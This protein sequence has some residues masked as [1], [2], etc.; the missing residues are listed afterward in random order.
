M[1]LTP[2]TLFSILRVLAVSLALFFVPGGIIQSLIEWKDGLSILARIPLAFALS[3]GGTAVLGVGCYLLKANLATAQVVWLVW[4]VALIGVWLLRAWRQRALALPSRGF[5]KLTWAD[6][7]AF[8]FALFCAGLAL[9]QGG[10]FSHRA[11]GFY[12]LAAIRRQIDQGLVLPQGLLYAYERQPTGLNST[13]GT[14][15]LSLALLT[16]WSGVDIT[17]L[18]QH[19]PI[20]LT[21]LLI[22]SFYALG[23]T[24]LKKP[25]LAF[26]ATLLQFVLYDKLDFRASV[27]PNQAGFILL[28][29][30]WLLVLRYLEFGAWPELVFALGLA[31]VMVSWHL[32]I[33]EFFVLGLVAYLLGRCLFLWL[34][35]ASVRRDTET[36][37]LLYVLVPLFLLGAPFVL[38]RV[39]GSGATS[40]VN[41]LSVAARPNFRSSLDL[42][43]GFSII[44]PAK[45]YLVDPRWRFA[46]LRFALWL[47][48]YL[49]LPFLI[50]QC[51]RRERYALFLLST[52]AIVPLI[53]FN[54][55]L[56]TYL[57]GKVLD[58]SLIRL[59]LLPLYGMVLAWFFWAQGGNWVAAMSDVPSLREWLR[60]HR[61]YRVP[62]LVLSGAALALVAGLILQQGVD[63]LLDLYAP[64]SP[65]TYSLTATHD[66]AR[67]T[68]QAPYAF[69]MARSAPGAV[70]ASDPESSYYVGGLTGRSVISVPPTHWPPGGGDAMQRQRDSLAILD[71]TVAVDATSGL[72]DKRQACFVWVDSRMTDFDVAAV[73]QKFDSAPDSYQRVYQDDL[74]SIYLYRN[75]PPGCAS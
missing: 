3:V 11:D 67:L 74:F 64:D 30:G 33:A 49:S 51:L 44:G 62:G 70:I 10:W 29:M 63:N 68:E 6:W 53:L 22:L 39:I 72:L 50:P 17:W 60:G 55:L 57:Q 40:H 21:P 36:R 75:H 8:V 34:S 58:I 66:Q 12:H 46:P 4:L 61:W 15:H 27:Y 48:T 59:V 9:Y 54:P 47:F 71:P 35:K 69:L 73:R 42:G 25:W 38:L 24:L 2:T 45:L 7:L 43:H 23:I 52:T 5:L 28:W 37:R 26:A 19:L 20:L 16:T 14:W 65:N 31:A 1:E 18:W 56:I 41:W 13:T 32:V